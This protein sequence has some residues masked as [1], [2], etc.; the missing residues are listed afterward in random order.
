MLQQTQQTTTTTQQRLALGTSGRNKI[1][2]LQ[3]TKSR[4][5]IV[6]VAAKWL[7]RRIGLLHPHRGYSA[8]QYTAHHLFQF[9]GHDNLTLRMHVKKSSLV[10]S[11]QT[12]ATVLT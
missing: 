10:Q 6:D 9:S 12:Y 11:H 5:E 3:E 1:T 8:F 2:N 4:Q 7:Q